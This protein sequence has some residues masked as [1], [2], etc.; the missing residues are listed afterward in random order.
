MTRDPAIRELLQRT[1]ADTVGEQYAARPSGA[2]PMEG[3]G[4]KVPKAADDFVADFWFDVTGNA[5]WADVDT[6]RDYRGRIA[7]TAAFWDTGPPVDG[8]GFNESDVYIYDTDDIARAQANGQSQLRLIN[9][10]VAQTPKLLFVDK[11]PG[12]GD[13]YLRVDGATGY[14]QA[15]SENYAARY[16][17]RVRISVGHQV[18]AADDH[19]IG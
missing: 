16:Q 4:D 8:G 11:S 1:R 6:T 19:D 9:Y 18:M 15:L 7:E 13:F 3:A 17:V 5:A 2:P 10:H 12:L 14:L